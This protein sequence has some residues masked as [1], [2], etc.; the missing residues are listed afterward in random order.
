M[1]PDSGP[2]LSQTKQW[3]EEEAMMFLHASGSLQI[4]QSVRSTNG[5]MTTDLRLTE[6][7]LKWKQHSW[8]DMSG[9]GP[10]S[11]DSSAYWSEVPLKDLEV[12]SVRVEDQK[13]VTA[14]PV[15]FIIVPTR[16]AVGETIKTWRDGKQPSSSG[17]AN[18]FA[19]SRENG[20]RVVNA[21]RRAAI[22]CGA[23]NSPF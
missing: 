19:S 2:T 3:L 22:L 6:C 23:P 4:G 18:M 12:R 20:Q 13:V 7:K 15:Q 8:F 16:Q 1:R 11:R 17:V 21:I 14:E 9:R 10:T 5:W